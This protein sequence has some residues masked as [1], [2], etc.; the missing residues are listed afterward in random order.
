MLYPGIQRFSS[1]ASLLDC[2]QL[3]KVFQDFKVINVI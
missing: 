2:L 1:I 3:V